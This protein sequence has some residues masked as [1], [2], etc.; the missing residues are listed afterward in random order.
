MLLSDFDLRRALKAG[1]LKVDPL[2][3][4]IQPASIDLRLGNTAL[5]TPRSGGEIDPTRGIMPDSPAVVSFDFWR[6]LQNDFL[7][8]TTMEWIEL[9][10]KLSGILVGKSSLARLGL[11]VESA[12]YVD[13]G[14]KGCPTLELKNL[15]PYDII[16]RPGMPIAQLRVEP[17]SSRADR[18]YGDRDLLSH[19]QGAGGPEMYRAT[20]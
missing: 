16:L 12:G 20:T 10:N 17:L 5:Q 11:Q 2:L 14:W 3:E 4:P 1:H 7:L 19:F 8:V 6:L 13:P 15:G 18:L 9:S